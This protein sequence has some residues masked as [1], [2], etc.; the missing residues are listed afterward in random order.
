MRRLCGALESNREFG[1][2]GSRGGCPAGCLCA[3][4]SNHDFTDG[5]LKPQIF[6]YL[7]QT[8]ILH[9]RPPQCCQSV[10]VSAFLDVSLSTWAVENCCSRKIPVGANGG[11]CG[12]GA[13]C[14]ATA[15]IPHR[16]ARGR[17]T[18]LCGRGPASPCP[19]KWCQRMNQCSTTS[20]SS[21][22]GT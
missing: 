21:P 15:L 18:F 4:S 5:C 19:R 17:A 22:G 10:V 12:A 13:G 6:Y 20:R 9:V 2:L 16:P 11:R 14:G 1:G 7:H 8:N 3:S